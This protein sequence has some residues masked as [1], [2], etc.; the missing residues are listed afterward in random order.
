MAALAN[1]FEFDLVAHRLDGADVGPD[2]HDAGFGQ[3]DGEGRALGQKAVAWVD[4][5][6]AGRLAGGDD[7]VDHEVGLRRGGR[8]DGDGLVRHFDMQSVFVGFRIDRNRL[9]P[10]ATRRLDDSA[11]DFA[12]IGDK[13]FLEHRLPVGRKLGL[14]VWGRSYWNIGGA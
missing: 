14:S 13:D 5:F 12:A 9:Y 10:H 3:G 1:F 4:G 8:P 11:G 2:E 6:R 7:L